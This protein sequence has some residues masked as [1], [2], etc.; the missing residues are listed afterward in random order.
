MTATG[1]R[2]E[3]TTASA[4]SA[5]KAIGNVQ[6]RERLQALQNIVGGIRDNGVT[7]GPFSGSQRSKKVLQHGLRA[8]SFYAF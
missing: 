4:R 2:H 7:S 8:F 5:S 6:H 3:A 1:K